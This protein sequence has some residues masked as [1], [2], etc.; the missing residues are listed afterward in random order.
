MKN[1]L[2]TNIPISSNRLRERGFNQTYDLAKKV[3]DTFNLDFCDTLIGRKDTDEHQSMKDRD[4][5]RRISQNDFLIQ[6]VID[7]SQYKSI[8]IIDDVITTGSTLES[9]SNVLRNQY[10]KELNINA[11][12]MFRGRPYYSAGC[13]DGISS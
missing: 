8:T 3:S 6:K 4:D 1:T 7:I 9:V 11:I 5:R 13:S 12:C 2:L 10:G